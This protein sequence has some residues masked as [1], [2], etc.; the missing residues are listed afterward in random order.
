MLP[1]TT[2]VLLVPDQVTLENLYQVLP[3]NLKHVLLYP[4][5]SKQV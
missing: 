2:T 3:D 1:V 4:L 5:G